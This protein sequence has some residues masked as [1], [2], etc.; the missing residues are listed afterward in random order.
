MV[1]CNCHSNH[2]FALAALLVLAGAKGV[3]AD[4]RQIARDIAD[5]RLRAQATE[6]FHFHLGVPEAWLSLHLGHFEDAHRD[7]SRWGREM[8]F[9]AEDER[10]IPVVVFKTRVE[11]E[12]FS[13]RIGLGVGGDAAG[14]YAVDH[15]VLLF[16]WNEFAPAMQITI[17]H[18]VAH[19]V[20]YRLGVHRRDLRNSPWLV[21]GLACMFEVDQK[22][23]SAGLNPNPWRLADL[24]PLFRPGSR[25]DH[26]KGMM[27]TQAIH[28]LIGRTWPLD[29]GDRPHQRRY[30]EAYALAYYL[31][32][33]NPEGMK[34][35]LAASNS[36]PA[37]IA[38]TPA[39]ARSEFSA[40]FGPL[41]WEFIRGWLDFTQQR[42]PDDTL[43]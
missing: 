10:P 5:L 21:E 23:G 28:D 25:C 43:P 4:D 16:V 22:E 24:R 39:V 41:E 32:E 26:R 40:A 13:K 18:E 29:E 8:G 6:R 30:A 9:T 2:S 38:L 11:F 27:A 31:C 17:R 33:T 42:L 19:A 36:R 35:Y 1:R 7:V 20:L 15:D 34:R 12:D 3:A 37:D 14:F